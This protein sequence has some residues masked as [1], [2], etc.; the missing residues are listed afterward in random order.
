MSLHVRNFDSY[1]FAVSSRIFCLLKAPENFKNVYPER[2]EDALLAV[3]H[4]LEDIT[5]ECVFAMFY[6]H[7]KTTRAR[8]HTRLTIL[9]VWTR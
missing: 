2:K 3:H 8:T 1:R 6:T 9:Q 4:V 5:C 7:S